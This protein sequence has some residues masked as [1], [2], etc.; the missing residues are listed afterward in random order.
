MSSRMSRARKPFATD[1]ARPTARTGEAIDPP[2]TFLLLLEGRA[3]GEY[4]AL[5]LSWPFLRRLPRGDGHPVLVLPGFMASDLSTRPL[6]RVLK[7]LGYDAHGWGLGR[8]TG[9]SEAARVGMRA[10]LD[11][12]FDGAR[13]KVSLIGWSLGGVYARELARAAPGKVRRVITL[14]SP[15]NGHPQ[16]NNAD[17]LYRRV[18]GV[19]APVDWEGF[20]RRRLPPDVPCTAIYSKTDGIVAWRCSLEDA[21][22]HTE[23]VEIRG[24][25]LGLGVNPQAIRVIADRLARP[26]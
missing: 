24:S 19:A 26:Q 17:A 22:P 16:A 10:R 18:N 5:M 20:N 12:L 25:H 3:F 1:E 21:A 15:I 6:R 13:S 9:A 8:N 14:G 23:N 11:T 7:R 4:A 2:S